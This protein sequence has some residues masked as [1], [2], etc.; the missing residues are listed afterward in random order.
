V[1]FNALHFVLIEPQKKV[2]FQL[3]PLVTKVNKIFGSAFICIALPQG[4][5]SGVTFF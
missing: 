5:N 3:P 2:D 1:I 4:E